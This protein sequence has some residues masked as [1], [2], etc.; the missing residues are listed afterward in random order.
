MELKYII[1]N[2]GLNFHEIG[3]ALI[4][5]FV[6]KIETFFTTAHEAN[7]QFDDPAISLKLDFL[8]FNVILQPGIYNEFKNNFWE[9]TKPMGNEFNSIVI[10]KKGQL[11]DANDKTELIVNLKSEKLNKI[12]K[13]VNS[14]DSNDLDF[15]N[16]QPNSKIKKNNNFNIQTNNKN[17]KNDND[18]L[19]NDMLDSGKKK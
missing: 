17:K 3:L 18:D 10:Y 4:L 8:P 5:D 13:P 16:D 7:L 1:E 12:T 11:L 2:Q 14:F 15:F 19:L 6:P 9:F